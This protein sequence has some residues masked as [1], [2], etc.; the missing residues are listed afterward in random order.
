MYIFD[1][2]SD[3]LHFLFGFFLIYLDEKKFITSSIIQTKLSNYIQ[4]CRILYSI[5]CIAFEIFLMNYILF[6]YL[7]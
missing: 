2:F 4:K 1:N 6:F 7:N 3:E 5:L